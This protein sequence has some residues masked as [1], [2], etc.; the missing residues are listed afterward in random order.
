MK[1]TFAST[2][3]RSYTTT[4]TLAA[5]RRSRHGAAQALA[6]AVARRS[7]KQAYISTEQ[8]LK[9]RGSTVDTSK[10]KILY[11]A[12]DEKDNCGVG[13]IANLKSKASRYVVDAADEMLVR[14]S[15]RGGVGTDPA[16]GDG[17][18]K[19]GLIQFMSRKKSRHKT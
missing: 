1:A 15:H 18:G 7:G 16:S 9:I 12:K 17:A 13:L 3:S 4:T 6:R 2:T 10:Q 11:D 5:A 14:M 8:A 19:F